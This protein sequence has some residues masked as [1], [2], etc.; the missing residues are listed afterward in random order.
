MQTT[1][2]IPLLSLFVVALIIGLMIFLLLV[3]SGRRG[4][5]LRAA[6]EALGLSYRPYASVSQ[7]IIDAHFHLL[8]IGQFRHFRH[9]L[10]GRL[11]AGPHVNLFDYSLVVPAGT[12]TQ[13]L[14]L[15]EAP[16]QGLSAFSINRDHWL[17]SDAFSES[18]HHPRQPLRNEQKPLLLRR[19]QVKAANPQQLWP[20]LTPEVCDWLLAHPHLHIEWSDG[21]LL[22]CR[23]GLLLEA[24]QLQPAIDQARLFIALLQHTQQ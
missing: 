17:S 8:D 1:L 6:G 3:D 9:L 15:V 11:N 10:E 4:A 12:S 24:E 19:W 13:T 21:I 22:V 2:M 5:A 7:R 16:L 18:H 23:P 14:L 20:R